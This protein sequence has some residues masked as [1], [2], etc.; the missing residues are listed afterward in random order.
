MD[1]ITP[2]ENLMQVAA[3]WE[4]AWI[5]D[6]DGYT[7]VRSGPGT[8]HPVVS[9]TYDD[10]EFEFCVTSGF[11]WEVFYEGEQECCVDYMHKPRIVLEGDGDQN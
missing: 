10:E 2:T 6:P 11:W 1:R 7:S 5:N 9:R 8:N 4:T 3:E